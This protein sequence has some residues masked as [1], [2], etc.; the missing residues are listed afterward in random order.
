MSLSA[1]QE[2]VVHRTLDSFQ[3]ELP[4]WAFANTGTRFG[5]FL[6]PSAAATIAEKLADAAEVNRV[7]GCCPT[8]AVHVLWD[9]PEGTASAVPATRAAADAGIRIGSVSPNVFQDQDTNTARSRTP[10]PPSAAR[11]STTSS[12]P[13]KSRNSRAAATYPVVHR[14]LELSRHR[15]HAAA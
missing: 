8:M 10:T 15:Q 7:T 12:T 5:K 4:S 9:F 6:D 14:R 11:R 13:S 2:E 1:K 3:I